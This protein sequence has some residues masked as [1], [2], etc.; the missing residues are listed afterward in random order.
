[1]ADNEKRKAGRI[2]LNLPMLVES[3]GQPPMKLHPNL[4]KVYSRVSPNG[5]KGEKFPVT[6][7][8]LS[9]NGAF[10]VGTPLPLLSRVAFSFELPDF[11]RIEAIGWTLWRRSEDCE[12]PCEGAE[13]FVLSQGFGLLFE[14]IPLDARMAI[15]RMVQKSITN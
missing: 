14:A 12:I 11:G 13:P 7:R 5:A 2:A 10:V 6:L 1:M 4:A 9:T 3:I 15:H 8:D